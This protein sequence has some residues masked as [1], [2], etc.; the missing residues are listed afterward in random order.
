MLASPMPTGVILYKVH[1]LFFRAKIEQICGQFRATV[2]TAN[3]SEELKRL[4]TTQKPVL[5]VLDLANSKLDLASIA[6]L[7]S[8]VGAQV[9][10]YYSHVDVETRIAA[11]KAGIKNITP[12]SGLEKKL[13]NL[14]LS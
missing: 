2:S 12:K 6:S 7:C 14:I 4:L 5:I 11:A 8:N 1:D 13:S 9:L 10:G 3:S